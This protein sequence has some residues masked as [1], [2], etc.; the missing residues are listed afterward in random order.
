M[1]C[2]MNLKYPLIDANNAA[3]ALADNDNDGHQILM[4]FS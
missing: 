4:R 2:V 1:D 3:D